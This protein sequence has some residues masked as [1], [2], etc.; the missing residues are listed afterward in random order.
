MKVAPKDQ[1]TINEFMREYVDRSYKTP[2]NA[3]RLNVDHT[4]AH[5]RTIFEVCNALLQ[6]KIPFFTEVRLKCG[7]IPDIVCPTH[8]VPF[9]E[10]LSSETIEMFEDLKLAKYP[11]EFQLR[12]TGSG[13]L[14]SFIFVDAQQEFS[15]EDL[16]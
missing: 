3:V 4:D 10:V 5:R 13:K 16:L 11:S 15:K 1:A 12:Y 8:V 9:I 14:K 2:M 7:T 6:E